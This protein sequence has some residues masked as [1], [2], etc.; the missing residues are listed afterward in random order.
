MLYELKDHGRSRKRGPVIYID[1][2]EVQGTNVLT[3]QDAEAWFAKFLTAEQVEDII[4]GYGASG[5]GRVETA[6]LP[7][8][9]L[10]TQFDTPEEEAIYA[11]GVAAVLKA[12][13]EGR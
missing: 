1:G 5:Y 6:P 7:E 4:C 9:K 2:I 11:R 10:K 12:L 8:A 3:E 13:S